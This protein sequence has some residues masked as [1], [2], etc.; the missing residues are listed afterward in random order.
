METV[1]KIWTKISRFFSQSVPALS[2]IEKFSKYTKEINLNKFPPTY[3]WNWMHTG[4]VT[5]CHLFQ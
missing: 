3:N 5:K 1:Q 4:K 2:E